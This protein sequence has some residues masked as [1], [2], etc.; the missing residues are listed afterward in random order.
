MPRKNNRQ[1][2]LHV[3]K[4]DNVKVIAGNEKGKEGR[5]LAVFP[6]KERVLVEGVNMRVHHD[7]PTQENPQGGRIEREV[8]IHISNVMVI[9]PSTGEPTRIGRKRIEEDGGGRWVRYAKNS[10]EIIDK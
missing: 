6:A 1:K 2:K 4:G 5:V 10:G 7:K 9:D 8:A 3:K